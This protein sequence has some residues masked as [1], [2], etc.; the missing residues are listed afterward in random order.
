MQATVLKTEKI[1]EQTMYRILFA[2]SFVHLLSDSVT[3]VI[4]AIF[5]ILHESMNLSFLQLGLIAFTLNITSS[6]SQPFIGWY[7]DSRPSPYLLPIGM[8]C[9]FLGMLLLA[10]A[11]TMALYFWQLYLLA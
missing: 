8:G 4:P 7:T 3:A 9:T 6:I 5:P 10:F 1:R 11:Q 2:I